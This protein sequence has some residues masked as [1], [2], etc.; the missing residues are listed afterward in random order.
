MNNT[1]GDNN[2]A[3]GGINALLSNT[4]G[5]RNVAVVLD[6]KVIMQLDV[7]LMGAPP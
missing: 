4:E 1:T 5:H 3:I 7:K 2:T 6:L